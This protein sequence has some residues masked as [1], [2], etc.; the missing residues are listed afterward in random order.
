[1]VDNVNCKLFEIGDASSAASA[2][3]S[4]LEPRARARLRA[5]GYELVRARYSVDASVAAWAE[6]LHRIAD[7]PLRPPAAISVPASG[8]LDRWFGVARGE[9][10]RKLLGV[11]YKHTEAGAEW[12]HS[13]GPIGD[14][15][16]FWRDCEALDRGDEST[17]DFQHC[18]AAGVL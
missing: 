5:G 10:I 3:P 7:L 15:A 16:A 9:R 1:M 12:P 18:G 13:Y 4:L 11:R 6:S 17:C 2:I 8:R 14:T